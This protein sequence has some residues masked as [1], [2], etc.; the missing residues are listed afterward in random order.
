M[1]KK[2]SVYLIITCWL[3][4]A[5][6]YLGKMNYSANIAQIIDFYNVGK[7]EAG[8]PPT[9]FFFAYG[10]GQVV[11]GL[12]CKK[13]NV[14][15]SI[16]SALLVSSAINLTVAVTD[17]FA[18][19]KWLWLING[20]ALSVL[21]PV[22]VRF[23]SENLH[24]DYLGKSSIVMG[25]PVAAG[26]LLVYLLSS[27]YAFFG[28]F[29]L[30]FYTASVA[31]IIISALWLI[32]YKHIVRDRSDSTDNT[33]AV[34]AVAA[35]LQVR[36]TNAQKHMLYISICVLCFF[37][38]GVNLI[39]EGLTTWVPSILKDEFQLTD[40]LSILLTLLL[41]VFAIFANFFALAMHRK[42]SDYVTQCFICFAISALVIFGITWGL[43]QKTVVVVLTGLLIVNF[44]A[45]SLNSLITSIFPVYMRDKVNSGM[46]AGIINGFCYLGSTV[47]A[48]GLGSIAEHFSWSGVFYT[49]IAVCLV[50]VVV[51]CGYFV[52]K[53]LNVRKAAV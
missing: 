43:S 15:W 23:M 3:I 52:I 16:F 21:W 24:E 31:V 11:N 41:P 14:K 1:K 39:K 4:Y 49:L 32:S 53:K 8:L 34:S 19:V 30:S 9:F 44:L 18:I 38:I 48:Y 6:S 12:L 45:S 37:A 42:V 26:T 46:I 20:F 10:V 27:I 33:R 2:Q 5:V 35:K 36:H 22:I 51:W 7:S 13:Y 40:A 47:S 29:K 25:T 17:N 50:C 28:N